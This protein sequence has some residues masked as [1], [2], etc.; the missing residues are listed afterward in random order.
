M[1]R[2]A[3]VI[4]HILITLGLVGGTIIL[5][6]VAP[7]LIAAFSRHRKSSKSYDKNQI[8]RSLSRLESN[9]L[10]SISIKDGK[11]VIRLTKNGEKKLLF[12]NLDDMKIKQPKRWDKQWRIV[13]FDIPETHKQNRDLFSRKLRELEF[14]KLQKSVWVCPYPCVDEIDFIKE[15]YEIRPFVRVVTASDID[16]KNDLIKKFNLV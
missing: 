9:E 5:A 15:I 8:K 12:Y 3:E 7:N 6:A 4:K 10:I 2:K 1:S 16:I 11:I 14:I 13:I